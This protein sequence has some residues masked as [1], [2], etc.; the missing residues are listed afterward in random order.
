MSKIDK[1]CERCHVVAKTDD[2]GV[3]HEGQNATI[4]MCKSCADKSCTGDILRMAYEKW[5][6]AREKNKSE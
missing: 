2:Y 4:A 1:V 6:F 5:D 3:A